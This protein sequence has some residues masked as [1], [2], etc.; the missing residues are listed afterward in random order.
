MPD[1]SE[2]VSR[3]VPLDRQKLAA[4]KVFDIEQRRMERKSD[5]VRSDF[6]FVD[7]PDWVNVVALTDDD[8]LV[9]IE[10]WR[11]ARDRVTLEIPGGTVDP[12]ES[13]LDAAERELKE[14]TGYEARDWVRLGDIEPN[15]AIL[16]NRC[17]TYLAVGAEKVADPDF[18]G[19]EHCVTVLRPWSDAMG[20]VADGTISHA[21]VVVALTYETLRRAR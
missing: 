7:C 17:F 21:L 8:D 5:G 10:Q 4:T 6:F 3:W 13:P 11:H 14:E 2:T 20:L 12:G 9:L 16:T 18:D 15:P 1:G 19:N